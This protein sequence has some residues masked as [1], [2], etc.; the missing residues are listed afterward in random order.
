MNSQ[1]HLVCRKNK[2]VACRILTEEEAEYLKMISISHDFNDE[3]IER[4]WLEDSSYI[5]ENNV[6]IDPNITTQRDLE[7]YLNKNS[8]YQENGC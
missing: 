7:W 8:E 3:G 4:Y 5:L 1:W 6:H 2:T